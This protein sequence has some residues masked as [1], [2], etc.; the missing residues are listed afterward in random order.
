MSDKL[1][2]GVDVAK[3]WI[4]V[5]AFARPGSVRV[6][7]TAAAIGAWL[8]ELDP[9]RVELVAFEPTGGYER[10]LA[11][12]LRRRGIAFARVHPNEVTAFRARRGVK[13]KTDAID[14]RLLAEFAAMELAG[15]GLR[16]LLEADDELRELTT[17]RR[18][19]LGTLH[20]ERCRAALVR[21]P[22]VKSSIAAAVALLVK[23]LAALEAAIAARIAASAP[24]A[25]M[26]ALL[27]SLKGVGPVT[28]A[29]LLGELPELGRLSG[30]EIAALVGLA[31]RQRDSGRTRGR[32]T[33]GHG[34]P[35]VRQV[36]F[37]VARAAI[38]GNQAMRATY[39]RLV[40]HN[41]RPGKVALTAVMRRMLVI[42][43]A[44]ARDGQP[45]KGATRQPD[46]AP[47]PGFSVRSQAVSPSRQ[48]SSPPPRAARGKTG[49]RPPPTAARSG[50]A[51]REHG[52]II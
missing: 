43:N 8:A 20:A 37:N 18:Q 36:L 6:A 5:A 46:I 14:A 22:I 10:L 17:R 31:P 44:I 39:E 4:D 45:W 50:L 23:D 48:P 40:M 26:A 12:S 24:L 15:R 32:A 41:R 35:G 28:V 38:R 7:Q 34:R 21:N 27:R 47:E 2:L 49:R 30:K 9:A 19:V 51:A 16:P 3:D 25:R 13:A 42:L 52:G 1:F 33:T 11:E 29:T